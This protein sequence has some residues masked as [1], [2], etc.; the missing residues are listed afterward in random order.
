MQHVEHG[1]SSRLPLHRYY[2]PFLQIVGWILDNQF[3]G[4]QSVDDLGFS[5]KIATQGNQL[6]MDLVVQIDGCYPGAL[7]IT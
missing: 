2:H 6:E 5:T 3:V 4:T 1:I 7:G